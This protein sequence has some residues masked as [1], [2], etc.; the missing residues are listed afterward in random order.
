MLPLSNASSPI[1]HKPFPPFDFVRRII[2]HFLVSLLLLAAAHGDE[3]MWLPQQV[4][5]LADR[6]R[7]LGYKGDAKAFADLTGFPMGAIVSL[8]GCSASFVSK[9]GLIVTNHHCVQA[10]LLFN[11]RPDRNLMVDG[12]LAKTRE[13]ELPSGPGSRVF[14]TVAVEDVTATILGNIPASVTGR[15]YFDLLEQRVKSATAEREKKDGY[16]CTVASFFEGLQYY[17]ITQLELRDVRLVYAP[18]AGI[19]NFGGE[20]DNWQWPRHTGDFS[21]LRAYVG[22]DGRPANYA[23][24]NV[25]FQTK[26]WLKVSGRGIAPDEVVFVAGYPGRTNRW[27]TFAAVKEN[28]EY[29]L[30]RTI[31][32]NTERIA[33]YEQLGASDPETALRVSTQLRGLNNVLTKTKGVHEAMVRGGVLAQ[34]EAKE[35]ELLAWIAANPGRQARYGN[36]VSDIATLTAERQKT[37]ESHLLLAEFASGIGSALGAAE[38]LY[39]RSVERAKPD[40]DRDP[41]YQQRNW[42]RSRESLDRLQRSL[43]RKADTAIMEYHLGAIAA[44]PADQRIAI[45]D[46]LIGLKAG[47]P[48]AEAMAAIRAWVTGVVQ[49]TQLYDRD[50]RLGLFEKTQAELAASSDSMLKVAAALYPA[51]D[52]IRTTT[53]QRGG[54][55]ARL[56]PLYAEAML[57]KEGGLLSPDANSTLRVTYGS[58]KGVESRDALYYL[59]Q[60]SLKGI[61]QK[62]TGTGEFNAPAAQLAAIKALRG[63]KSTPY[64]DATLRDVPVNF[65]STVDTTGGNSGSATLN[66]KHELVGLLFDGTYDTVASDFFFD[67]AQTRS[68]HCDTRYMLWIMSEVDHADHLLREMTIT[69]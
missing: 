1:C 23:Q 16:R 63:G 34:K 46:R 45:L 31:K 7:A 55:L 53:K 42:P 19:G 36:V 33:I 62:A 2:T 66:A 13:E 37:R 4:P 68:I 54:A 56:T 28:V 67:P 59:P 24:D 69:R 25:P 50:F 30:P 18:A 27:D 38:T 20:A 57:A 52:A 35:K 39:R 15:A 61:T 8:G 47:Q 60:T 14:V 58:I 22:K 12:Y 29:L 3:G 64:L 6:L 21:F 17:A 32:R 9:D 48:A 5:A 26:H 11:S 40:A 44:L 49:G 65:L 43:D 10:A 51:Q 41:V